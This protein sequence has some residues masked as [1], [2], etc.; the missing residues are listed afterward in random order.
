MIYCLTS[1]TRSRRSAPE[2]P[3]LAFGSRSSVFKERPGHPPKAL[4]PTVPR[5]SGRRVAPAEISVPAA[6]RPPTGPTDGGGTCMV[7]VPHRA[8]V[9]ASRRCSGHIA[10]P[11]RWPGRARS[12]QACAVSVDRRPAP[13]PRGRRRPGAS[14]T[15][16]IAGHPPPPG[17]L[18]G[19]ADPDPRPVPGSG[20][21]LGPVGAQPDPRVAGQ[22]VRPVEGPGQ[23]RG[24]GTAWPGRCSRSRSRRAAGRAAHMAS[25]PR[26][27]GRRPQED[28]PGHRLG[29]ADDVGAPVHAVGEVHVQAARAG[30]T[31]WR[32]GRSARG[33]RARPG[34]PSPGRPPP[35][36][37][38]RPARRGRAAC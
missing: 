3:A 11:T 4:V 30:R 19:H 38:G 5:S 22:Q 16:R 28:R 14:E 20:R 17:L 23:A 21:R 36:R 27:R 37:S 34:P 35:R 33:R 32:C 10:T 6:R 1:A 31:W 25:S 13:G 7:P 12:A 18:G 9:K 26:H 2:L 29:P 15:W 24:P 8:T